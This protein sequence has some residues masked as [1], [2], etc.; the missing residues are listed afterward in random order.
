MTDAQ[1]HAR[2]QQRVEELCA[3]SIRALSG[4]PDV[5]FRAQRLHRGERALPR[6]APH[7]HPRLPQDD[8]A[9]FRG[10]ADGLALRLAHSDARAH[11]RL[12][13]A[14]PVPQMLFELLEQFRAESR[15]A[16][17][18]SGVRRNLRHRFDAWSLAFHHSGGTESARGLLV[19]TVAQICRSHVCGDPV[20]EEIEDLLE[21]TRAALA[22]VLGNPLAALKRHRADQA[23]YAVPA[24]EI[25]RHVA[26]MLDADDEDEATPA[27]GDDATTDP[28]AAF[29]LLLDQ[30][31]SIDA[32][33][34]SAVSGPSRVLDAAAGRYRVFTTAYDREVAAAELV[35][36]EVL[37]EERERLDARIA[38]G[39]VNLA[40]LAR[41]LKA[42]L[43]LPQHDGWDSAHEQ[44][45]I[46]GRRLSQLIASPTER[47]LFRN[48]RIEPMA[49]CR[50]TFLIDCS[51]SMKEHAETVAALVDVLVRA[52]ELIDVPAEVLGF[53]TSAWNGGRAARDWRR[54]GKP[55]HPGRL[56]EACH[57]VFK[58]AAQR[59]R[60]A[61]TS[62]A[63]LLRGELFREGLDGEALE[64]ALRRL[65]SDDAALQSAVGSDADATRRLLFVVSDG[66]PMDSATSLANDNH[67]LDQHLRNVVAQHDGAGVE[68]F[69][70]GV[71]LDLSP[72][73]RR[74]RVLDLSEPASAVLRDVLMLLSRRRGR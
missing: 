72:Y 22:P 24:L 34:A 6:F 1:R 19:F 52:L 13:P 9:S 8:F 4:V 71:G 43:A 2:A 23:A 40:R 10:A 27:D 53:T 28:W 25:A 74:C 73:Y 20:T 70:L 16:E 67:Y 7:L 38:Q 37:K 59:W 60:A 3:A 58:P 55:A 56:N 5:S 26:A 39:G 64:W 66:S 42:V 63:A 45:L 49:A 50:V 29:T 31:T 17:S 35:R 11:Q 54:A 46:D 41:E 68:I 57:I 44:G 48:P 32:T 33:V 61:R 65:R 69:G 12:R 21:A 14:E 30:G 47:R 36:A 15:C 51:G 62:M 18:L